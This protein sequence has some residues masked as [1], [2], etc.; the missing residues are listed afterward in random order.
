[1]MRFGRLGPSAVRLARTRALATAAAGTKVAVV[2]SG[3]GVYDGAEVTEAVA[4][5]VH[6][7]RAGASV[8]CFA[9][10]KAQ[11]HTID[12]TKG[13]PTESRYPTRNVLTESARISRGKITPLTELKAADFS[14]LVI[15]GGF[16]AAKNL[17]N[18]A[19]VAQGDLSTLQIDEDLVSSLEGFRAAGKPI[20]LCCIAPVIAAAVLKCEVT[21]GQPSG[22]KW[23]YGGTA[24][25]INA[26]G[27]THV[28]TDIHGVH[29]DS[30]SKVVTSAAYMCMPRRPNPS[31]PVAA[32]PLER[33][34]S[35][36]PGAAHTADRSN[37]CL[38]PGTRASRSRYLT[39]SARWWTR[40]SSLLEMGGAQARP[41][42]V[43]GVCCEDLLKKGW[44]SPRAGPLTRCLASRQSDGEPAAY[45]APWGRRAG[46]QGG[47]CRT[48]DIAGASHTRPQLAHTL[49]HGHSRSSV[50][51]GRQS[52]GA[53]RHQQ[54]EEAG[55]DG[56]AARR[57]QIIKS[58]G[59]CR[60]RLC[61]RR[62][63]LCG[64]GPAAYG[65]RVPVRANG[66]SDDG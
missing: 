44:L 9:P 60:G 46:A 15:P 4:S 21:V 42:R 33:R 25:A 55:G 34:A 40:Y 2:L 19:T 51:D 54:Y 45:G 17:C 56:V 53:R 64:G 13:E 22:D 20:G 66:P 32:L 1:M 52:H 28:A 61:R 3:C 5:L 18:H 23:P 47:P 14:A 58:R 37:L 8:T 26:Y 59:R 49:R 16:G 35:D 31:T 7:T 48:D 65:D 41:P 10:D 27:G 24:D 50:E 57:G 11:F 6:L 30:A 38:T 39:A 63:P 36:A 29:V 43:R 62:P 12:H